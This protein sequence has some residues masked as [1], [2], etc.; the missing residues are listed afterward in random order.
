MGCNGHWCP[1]KVEIHQI[2]SRF[3]LYCSKLTNNDQRHEEMYSKLINN[4]QRNE[5]MY[6]KL[7]DNDHWHGN[8]QECMRV[9][10]V[11]VR[12]DIGRHANDIPIG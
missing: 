1:G 9:T 11:G 3:S 4:E 7:T 12:V 5:E 6:S 10:E 2:N 8:V